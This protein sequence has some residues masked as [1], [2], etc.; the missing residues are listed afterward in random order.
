MKIMNQFM[1][2]NILIC[3]SSVNRIQNIRKMDPNKVIITFEQENTNDILYE[4]KSEKEEKEMI[5]SQSII[6]KTK[7]PLES[8]SYC[9][10]LQYQKALSFFKEHPFSVLEERTLATEAMVEIRSDF[11]VS[12]RFFLC[13]LCALAMSPAG[14]YGFHELLVYSPSMRSKGL[15]IFVCL[16]SAIGFVACIA[17]SA[18][19]IVV[20]Y[21]IVCPYF[22]YRDLKYSLKKTEN[23]FQEIQRVLDFPSLAKKFHCAEEVHAMNN[24]MLSE[25]KACETL[26]RMNNNNLKQIARYCR[27]YSMQSLKYSDITNL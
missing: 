24:I 26:T 3:L 20:I 8:K 2:M 7:G 22:N 15:R 25:L 17:M 9:T 4:M 23:K 6:L 18:F 21:A 13:S 19:E 11:R 12:M 27:F 5:T 16:F 10:L 1:F 14:I